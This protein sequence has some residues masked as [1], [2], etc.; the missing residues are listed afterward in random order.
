MQC[1]FILFKISF[2]TFLEANSEFDSSI[3]VLDLHV[4]ILHITISFASFLLSR[5]CTRFFYIM[6][7]F[8]VF[9]IFSLYY[10]HGMDIFF[11]LRDLVPFVQ[12]K[13]REKHPWM[14]FTF[15]SPWVFFTFCKLY[16]W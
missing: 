8:V 14:S 4:T 15:T 1:S 2:K 16:K 13:K 9:P 10:F 6:S 7:E 12:F 5:F 11:L 3:K